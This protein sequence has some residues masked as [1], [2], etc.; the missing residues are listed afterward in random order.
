MVN[1]TYYKLIMDNFVPFNAIKIYRLKWII[2]LCNTV[3]CGFPEFVYILQNKIN[4]K[5]IT[6]VICVL[7]M[8]DYVLINW[9]Y[10]A[11][12]SQRSWTFSFMK[13]AILASRALADHNIFRFLC[14]TTKCDQ[15]LAHIV[16]AKVEALK[17]RRHYITQRYL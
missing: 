17:F 9:Y 7:S 8:W 15:V 2:T 3:K 10:A 14:S 5:L 11:V 16:H 12:L 4:V 6:S 1:V 13:F